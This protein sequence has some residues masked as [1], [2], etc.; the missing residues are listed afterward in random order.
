MADADV[1]LIQCYFVVKGTGVSKIKTCRRYSIKL[2]AKE[3]LYPQL[4][5]QLWK[6]AISAL[7]I[8]VHALLSSVSE[9][10]QAEQLC[11]RW[12]ICYC[13]PSAFLYVN[14]VATKGHFPICCH[15]ITLPTFGNDQ[16]WK[17]ISTQFIFRKDNNK[18]NKTLCPG[19]RAFMWRVI[20]FFKIL[21]RMQ[22]LCI[23]P[24]LIM[25]DCL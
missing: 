22:T 2:S 23:L 12:H 6:T 17:W 9:R 19:Q 8:I 3:T 4:L 24:I 25:M 1:Q 15:E 14:G 5:W 21:F 18:W 10:Q 16:P 7:C 20:F 11:Q 13:E